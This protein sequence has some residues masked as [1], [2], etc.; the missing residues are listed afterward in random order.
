MVGDLLFQRQ[1][2][3]ARRDFAEADR[4]RAVL[5]N[6]GVLVTDVGGMASWQPGP[7]FDATKLKA[8]Q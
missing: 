3:R 7:D 5:T 1:E 6:A 2:A 8:L 4:I